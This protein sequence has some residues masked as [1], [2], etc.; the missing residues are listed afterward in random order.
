MPSLNFAFFTTIY[1]DKCVF[2]QMTLKFII[3]SKNKKSDDK[4]NKLNKRKV[5]YY[6][7]IGLKIIRNLY[8]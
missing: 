4:L 6:I 7:Y 5:I 2:L 1:S 8:I 3:L